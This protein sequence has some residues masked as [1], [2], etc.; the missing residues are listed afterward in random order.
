MPDEPIEQAVTVK[1]AETAAI[2]ASETAA[3]ETAHIETQVTEVSEQLSEHTEAS[4]ERHEQ[5]LEAETWQGQR[6]TEV[7]GLLNPMQQSLLNLQQQQIQTQ[8]LLLTLQESLNRTE[9]MPASNLP[10]LPSET[11]APS[12]E[13]E[14]PAP[15]IASK[16]KHYKAI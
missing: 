2:V 6:L 13:A 7:L 10:N 5:I 1:A 15:A 9:L 14:N 16:R 8:T 4:E 11:P 3:L 12:E